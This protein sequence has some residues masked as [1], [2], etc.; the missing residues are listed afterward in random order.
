MILFTKELKDVVQ[1]LDA[2]AIDVSDE[3][4]TDD[5]EDESESQKESDAESVHQSSNSLPQ[6]TDENINNEKIR[7]DKKRPRPEEPSGSEKRP[8][9]EQPTRSFLD[10]FS[11]F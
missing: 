8:K 4:N 1:K 10:L 2:E 9:T 3:E 5:A 7:Q 11:H 6:P